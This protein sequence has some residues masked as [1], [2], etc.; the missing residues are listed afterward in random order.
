M[1]PEI[2]E[3]L[4][5][6]ERVTKSQEVPHREKYFI[7]DLSGMRKGAMPASKEKAVVSGKSKAGRLCS[8]N[9]RSII[10]FSGGS[11]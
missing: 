3:N 7:W 9:S 5:G 11:F 8:Y 6:F 10:V 2:F 4:S 1:R